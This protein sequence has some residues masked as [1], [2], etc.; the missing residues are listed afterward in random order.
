MKSER[1]SMNAF[2]D[3]AHVSNAVRPYSMAVKANIVQELI[4]C[5]CFWYLAHNRPSVTKMKP[6]KKPLRADMKIW[7]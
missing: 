1:S 4:V 3:V 2:P 6:T 7:L 5:N